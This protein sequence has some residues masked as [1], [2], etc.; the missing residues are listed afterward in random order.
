VAAVLEKFRKADVS[1]NLPDQVKKFTNVSPG[2][3]NATL[4]HRGA[5]S[6]ADV[7]VEQLRGK[8]VVLCDNENLR[9]ENFKPGD[10]YY[11]YDKYPGTSSTA[12]IRFCG[13]YTGDLKTAAKTSKRDKG[14]WSAEGSVK[15]AEDGWLEHQKHNLHD[16]LWW[17]YWQETGGN[18]SENTAATKGMHNRLENFLS[19]FRA[20][21]NLPHPNVI[22]QDFVEKV[23]CGAIVKMNPDL[24]TANFHTQDYG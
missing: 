18:V 22:G 16:H 20:N 13:K 23:T 21:T 4:F 10:G 1:E 8:L 6:L 3:T 19:K 2:K 17:V 15:N 7:E 11:L 14:N 9:S 24:A 5:K 12:Q